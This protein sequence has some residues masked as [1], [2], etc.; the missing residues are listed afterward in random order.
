[1]DLIWII[2]FIDVLASSGGY[3]AIA[4]LSI[5]AGGAVLGYRHINHDFYD[6]EREDSN[7]YKGKR[8]DIPYKS[9]VRGSLIV[10][11]M[12]VFLET[13]LPEKD[14]MY[15]MLAAYGVTEIAQTD[16][17]KRLGGKSLEVLE[18]VLDEYLK[19]SEAE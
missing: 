9:I 2:Y 1:M 7:Y 12:F 11:A 17:A 5:I 6:S 18:K 8:S 4:F 13:F 15:K 14:T 10:F 16:E 3:G 19:E